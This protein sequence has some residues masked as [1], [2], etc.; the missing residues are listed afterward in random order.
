MKYILDTNILSEIV[1]PRPD[2]NTIS[3]IQ[4]HTDEVAITSVSLEELYYGIFLMSDG[5][6]KEAL[7]SSIDAIVKDCTNRTLAFDAFCGYLCAEVHANARKSGHTG[8]IEDF[9]IAAI[10]KRNDAVLVTHN[11]K[12]F[13]YVDG[14]EII[15][16]FTYESP[17]LAELK[18][19]EAERD[20]R[21][22]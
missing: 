21:R 6:K 19:R 10:C 9:M 18:R 17:L 5:K 1:K 16:P 20:E 3:W 7:K 2:F 4:D 22:A 12:D 15:D 8:T 13:D 14:L 11:V